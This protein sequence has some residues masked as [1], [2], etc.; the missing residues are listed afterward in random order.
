MLFLL[1][2]LSSGARGAGRVMDQF[3]AETGA[4]SIAAACVRP[5]SAWPTRTAAGFVFWVPRLPATGEA[6]VRAAPEPAISMPAGPSA[7]GEPG[8]APPETC[9]ACMIAAVFE[10]AAGTPVAL[11]A[12]SAAPPPNVE[13]VVLDEDELVEPLASPESV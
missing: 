12:A 8:E 1:V 11:A 13:V 4:V 5:A 3:T 2:F 6:C 9:K 10:P 7:P